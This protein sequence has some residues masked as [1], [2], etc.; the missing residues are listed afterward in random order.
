M[1]EK[2]FLKVLLSNALYITFL[3]FFLVC[4]GFV[5]MVNLLVQ[6]Q[7]FAIYFSY[8]FH[9]IICDPFTLRLLKRIL[10]DEPKCTFQVITLHKTLKIKIL[11]HNNF[12]ISLETIRRKYCD[13]VD[14]PHSKTVSTKFTDLENIRFRLPKTTGTNTLIKNK[15]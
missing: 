4:F 8:N 5:C 10:N 13:G 11:A 1:F 6:I 2:Y 12:P 7:K 9:E 14:D 3:L 15:C